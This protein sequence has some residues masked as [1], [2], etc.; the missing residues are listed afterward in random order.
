MGTDRVTRRLLFRWLGWF[1]M[2]NAFV[3][4]VIDLRYLNSGP[5][6]MT[7]LSWLYLVTIY[8]SHH[9]LL[10]LLPLLLLGTPLV[11]LKPS[12]RLLRPVAVFL[13]GVMIA[14]IVLDSLL[15]SQGRFHLNALTVQILGLRSWLFVGVMFVIA[16][17][18][19]SLLAGRV[20]SWVGVD[21]RRHGRALAVVLTISFLAAQGIYVW[22]DASYYVPVTRVA[23]QLPVQRGFTAK[24]FLVRHG[25]LDVK[26]KRARRLAGRLS[27]SADDKTAGGSLRYPLEPLRCSA[28]QP[29]N[30]LIVLV[31]ALRSDMLDP[32]LTPR[33]Y[34]FAQERAIRFRHHYSGGNSSRIGV[35]SLFYGLPPGYFNGIEAQQIPPVLVD[36]L[37]ATGYQPG[38]FSSSN[39]YRPAALDR[40]AFAAVANLRM[41][42]RPLDAPAWKRDRIM[43]RDWTDWLQRR[44]PGRPFFG[45]L[46][47]D[48][49]NG[50]S[51]P[52][53]FA[54]R[55]T[56][57]A[58]PAGAAFANYQKAAAFDDALI[59]N[60]LDDLDRR[61][62]LEDT[63]V[64]I[65]ADH[66]EEFN[67]NHD[68]IRGHGSGYSRY[69]L[70]V[71]LLLAWPGRPPGQVV[72]RT[73]HYD[74]A[75]TLVRRLLGCNNPPA[76][77]SI[78]RDLLNGPEWDWLLAGSYYNYALIE[79]GQITVTFPNGSYEVRDGE[80][81]LLEK[82][83]LNLRVLEDAM[84]ENS[85]FYQP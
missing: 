7:P 14:V 73:S 37:L 33:L 21:R 44:D 10:A 41:E 35:F 75:A 27:G 23:Q 28:Q 61:G 66:G 48:A 12:F 54:D 78:G 53:A 20:W 9:A 36:Q 55:G 32:V 67:E 68:G 81:R 29:L 31:D 60:V 5:A 38:L 17:V 63:V 42:T 43:T 34:R 40:T 70:G 85:R 74:I 65:T 26:Q 71:P 15:W 2:V 30:L 24:R 51:Y 69:Q 50:K 49:V 22:A 56:P 18:F 64:L 57:A 77:Y 39:M 3:L 1:A 25:L 13:L 58:G 45:F 82:P 80:Y 72:R 8:C 83:R 84:Y 52:P 11:L 16:L 4:G 76:D 79:P 47:Y 59:G 19:E 6:D 46:F 62:L